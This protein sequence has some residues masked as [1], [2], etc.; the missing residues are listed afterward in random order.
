ME[1]IEVADEGDTANHD[2]GSNPLYRCKHPSRLPIEQSDDNHAEERSP[3]RISPIAD[4][5]QSGTAHGIALIPEGIGRHGAETGNDKEYYGPVC[6]CAGKK[7]RSQAGIAIDGAQERQHDEHVGKSGNALPDGNAD[8]I[9]DECRAKTGN[10]T[11]NPPSQCAEQSNTAGN[12]S[13][14]SDVRERRA[15]DDTGCHE[16]DRKPCVC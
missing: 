7:A 14:W 4:H 2:N 13:R 8:I 6:P 16:A 12:Q 1:R 3:E 10:G 11:F 5:A 15:S 9:I